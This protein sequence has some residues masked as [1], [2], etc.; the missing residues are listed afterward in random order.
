MQSRPR[1]IS[2]GSA[3][4]F[5]KLV[6]LLKRIGHISGGIHYAV[7]DKD[8][9]DQ[10]MK[11]AS[12]STAVMAG[13]IGGFF[14]G[15]PIVAVSLGIGA[16][17]AMDATIT[18][19]DT[20]VHWK[21]KEEVRPFGL[22]VPVCDP[23]NPGKWFDAIAGMVGD[24]VAAHGAGSLA[25]KA[26]MKSGARGPSVTAVEGIE[27][28]NEISPSAPNNVVD[29]AL[30]FTKEELESIPQRVIWHAIKAEFN[31]AKEPHETG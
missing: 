22:S 25:V 4:K 3:R 8:G 5:H 19:I 31:K 9:G 21:E 16:G 1:S 17:A 13:G 7:G 15:G 29:G 27:A 28:I 26:G 11:A 30:Y 14:I 24:G 2:P 12:H 18:G 6:R 23:T 10:A 20:A